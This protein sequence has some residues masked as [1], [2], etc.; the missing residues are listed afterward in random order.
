MQHLL[1]PDTNMIVFLNS[2]LKYS[3]KDPFLDM[4]FGN[5]LRQNE[6]YEVH[7]C[8]PF[9]KNIF[10]NHLFHAYFHQNIITVQDAIYLDTE[11]N[12]KIPDKIYIANCFKKSD[13]VVQLYNIRHMLRKNKSIRLVI[14]DSLK[15][16]HIQQEDK[17]FK[18]LNEKIANYDD[19]QIIVAHQVIESI[20]QD[21][22]VI[23]ILM[24]QQ[25][26]CFQSMIILKE[27]DFYCEK[28][29]PQSLNGNEKAVFLF[30]YEHMHTDV[31]EYLELQ[32][33]DA[34]DCI[35][36]ALLQIFCS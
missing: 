24:I 10:L 11:H 6:V 14:I 8:S 18:N 20:K 13:V 17:Q 33:I 1:K 36:G 9:E 5:S 25:R 23:V 12:F 35:F 4:Y 26:E 31:I 2:L 19:E 32:K 30:S 27:V 15:Y 7:Y 28:K 21:F 16:L 3:L 22:N 29:I 34:E